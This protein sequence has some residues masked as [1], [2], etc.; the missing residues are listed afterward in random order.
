[1]TSYL[2][3]G[4]LGVLLVVGAVACGGDEFVQAAGGAGG[5]SQGGAG[6]RDRKSVV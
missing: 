1:M 5:S 6:G 3:P 2:A 4:L